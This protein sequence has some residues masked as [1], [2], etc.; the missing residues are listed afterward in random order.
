MNKILYIVRHAKASKED[1][2][3]KD[4]ERSLVESGVERANKIS[5]ALKKHNI[6]PGKILTS[7]AFR[8]LN[9]AIIFARVLDYPV[10]KIEIT[11]DIYEKS[12]NHILDLIMKQD[13]AITSLMIFGHNPTFTDLYNLLTGDVA[14][15]L[16]TCC[17]AGIQF[18][19]DKWNKIR[20]KT[21]KCILI[22]TEKKE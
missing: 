6:S 14:E 12:P 13:D 8:A 3:I 17:V 20:L 4:W 16:P 5:K 19:T 1:V 9:T 22:E 15:S 2:N 18:E 11:N 7:H 10:S 21:G